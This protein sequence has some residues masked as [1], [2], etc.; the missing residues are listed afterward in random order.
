MSSA[1]SADIQPPDLETR[2]AILR[3]KARAIGGACLLAVVQHRDEAC[4]H[5]HMRDRTADQ[6]RAA[7]RDLHGHA[8]ARAA[9]EN[10]RR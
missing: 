5:G 9:P 6:Q 2:C 10:R 8:H 1:L 7:E 3:E 4:R